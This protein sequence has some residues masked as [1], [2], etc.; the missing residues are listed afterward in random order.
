MRT[1]RAVVFDMDGTIFDSRLDWLGLREAMGLVP[2]GRPIMSQLENVDE[3]ERTRCL[4]ILHEAER[5]GAET[6]VLVDGTRELLNRLKMRGI[7]CAL[8][9]NNSRASADA[10]LRRHPLPFNLVVTRDDGPMKPDGAAFTHTLSLLGVGPDEVLAIG[11]THLDAIAAHDA[12]IENIVLVG[13]ADWM[14]SHLPTGARIRH[15]RT[16]GEA[17]AHVLSLLL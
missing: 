10:V 4:A 3:S 11:D 17:E 13:L 8:L 7:L 16:L 1:L 12:G 6:G 5:H 9:T 15:V 14:H 2:D